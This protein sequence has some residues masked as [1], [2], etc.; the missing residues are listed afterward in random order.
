VL[1][2]V[3]KFAMPWWQEVYEKVGG[4]TG[5]GQH[6]PVWVG[7]LALPVMLLLAISESER[8]D[9]PAAV[10]LACSAAAFAGVLIVAFLVTYTPPDAMTVDSIE[11]RYFLIFCVLIG[12]ALVRLG[13]SGAWLTKLGPALLVATLVMNACFLIYAMRFYDNLW[14]F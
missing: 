2:T 14:I 12:W 1:A 7:W 6:A 3:A 8:R 10:I 9:L 5:F 11:G 13:W 4:V